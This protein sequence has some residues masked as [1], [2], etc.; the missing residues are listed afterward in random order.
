VITTTTTTATSEVSSD[1]TSKRDL[2]DES[3]I[4]TE[5]IQQDQETSMN[6]TN[7]DTII[8]E[9]VVPVATRGTFATQ[10]IGAFHQK[11]IEV[12]NEQGNLRIKKMIGTLQELVKV[13]KDCAD[14]INKI[15]GQGKANLKILLSGPGH[16]RNCE[17][18]ISHSWNN[19][20]KH[21]ENSAKSHEEYCIKSEK[22]ILE[23]DKFRHDAKS[24]KNMLLQQ[25]DNFCNDLDQ[26][27]IKVGAAEKKWLK[28]CSKAEDA[29]NKLNK[30][31]GV[32]DA[33]TVQKLKQVC[34]DTTDAVVET[35][36]QY[37]QIGEQFNQQQ[38]AFCE[39]TKALLN[40][41]QDKEEKRVQIIKSTLNDFIQ[42]NIDFFV[43]CHGNEMK[44]VMRAI[45]NISEKSQIE[46]T[47][48]AYGA[49]QNGGSNEDSIVSI[50]DIDDHENDRKK[51][52]CPYATF[53]PIET[54]GTLLNGFLRAKNVNIIQNLDAFVTD[55]IQQSG[56]NGEEGKED[57]ER[58]EGIHE[59]WKNRRSVGTRRDGN[60]VSVSVGGG[61]SSGLGGGGGGI[62][63]EMLNKKESKKGREKKKKKRK[64]PPML[65]KPSVSKTTTLVQ[66]DDST[67]TTAYPSKRM[68]RARTPSGDP[69]DDMSETE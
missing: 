5:E 26:M 24:N 53:E 69:D 48:I 18:T 4:N 1:T 68:V 58:V 7:V 43:H 23:F 19:I 67:A 40:S 21:F 13:Q 9:G 15:V 34:Q 20:L 27:K 30:K 31:A 51:L 22:I 63:Q 54:Q 38:S 8:N 60:D 29:I 45:T 6:E 62:E 10:M 41:L 64:P 2:E 55:D 39:L 49:K 25:Y 32:S 33:G 36:K 47:A 65:K 66:Q 3:L 11:E 50:S 35:R 57:V 28:A 17:N 42:C 16:N 37:E 12:L 56:G 44:S 52:W 14:A 59:I 46:V 61:S